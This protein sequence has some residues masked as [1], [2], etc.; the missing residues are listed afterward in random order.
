MTT[1]SDNYF[2]IATALFIALMAFLCARLVTELISESLYAPR[3]TK[4]TL[5]AGTTS[6]AEVERL[7]DYDTIRE[8]NLFN[9]DPKPEAPLSNSTPVAEPNRNIPA[10]PLNLNVTLVATGVRSGAKSFAVIQLNGE[11]KVYFTGDEVAP[12]VKLHKVYTDKV[13]L[14]RGSSRQEVLLF[15]PDAAEASRLDR[16]T[17]RRPTAR[18]SPAPT[19]AP[20]TSD[21]SDTIR[22]VSDTSYIIDRREIEQASTNLSELI[23]QLR[24]VPNLV[25]GQHNGFR[26]FNIKPGSLFTKIGINNNDIVLEVNGR[27]LS[28]IEQAYQSLSDLQ[29]ASSI[30]INLLRNN[31]P[32]TLSYE[33]R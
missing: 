27:P 24:V 3:S 7:A 17:A 25:N 6:S 31:Q 29:S 1:A 8:R 30:S 9:K 19:P 5:E 32:M 33:I 28:G 18:R 12:S 23:T 22:Q 4:L 26:V 11:S 13:I 15:D 2:K 10:P 14:A 20:V 21:P 16:R